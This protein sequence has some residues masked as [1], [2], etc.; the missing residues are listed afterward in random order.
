MTP[1]A[2]GPIRQLR[3]RFF[4]IDPATGNWRRFFDITDLAGVRQ[5]DPE[6]FEQT[7]ELVLSLVRDGLV[8][9]LR[10]DHPDGLAD[11]AGYL[12]RL[13]ERGVER[14][15]VEKILDP[16]EQLRDWPVV[17]HRRLRVPQRRLRAVRRPRRRGGADRACGSGSRATRG[18]LA[19]SR[20]EA[21]LE[22]VHGSV[23]AGA[24]AA[25]S[26]ASD[27]APIVDALARALASLPVYRTYV[28]P[29]TGRVAEDDR[30]A[31]AAADMPAELAQMLLLERDGPAGVRDPLPADHA[32]GDGQGRRGHGVLPLRAA[33]RAERGRRR[34]GPLR[35]RASSSSTRHAWSGRAASR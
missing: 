12:S 14:V 28:E 5:E 22:Q 21:K 34:S 4:D 13:R 27:S 24:R 26:R 32:R 20:C 23:R 15:W 7:H 29:A 2:T 19:R 3:E 10:I 33:A 18:P 31:I 30:D 11:P 35:D 1:T 16:G 6:V 9:G 8:D 17:G 25:R